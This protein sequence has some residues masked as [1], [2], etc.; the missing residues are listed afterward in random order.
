MVVTDKG[1]ITAV[2]VELNNF[3]L[4]YAVFGSRIICLFLP[5]LL[6]EN[7]VLHDGITVKTG[8]IFISMLFGLH[9]HQKFLQLLGGPVSH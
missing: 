7:H 1:K 3:R 6:D 9:V 2:T 4:I 8:C 5:V